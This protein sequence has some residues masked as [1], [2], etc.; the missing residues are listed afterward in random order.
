[1]TYNKELVE[2][3]HTVK[4]TV[5][6]ARLEDI[7]KDIVRVPEEH[8]RDVIGET[9][10]ESTVCKITANH[11]S[12]YAVLRGTRG[13]QAKPEAVA[14]MD[15]KTRNRLGLKKGDEIEFGFKHSRFW[16]QWWW[17]WNASET[18]FRV[19]TRLALVSLALGLLGFVLGVIA[20]I[21]E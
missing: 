21:W 12:T 15:D 11:K 8:R 19:A 17:A 13:V 4:L 6:A 1:M 18:A 10:E 2:S 7:Y 3:G 16:G 9:I 14:M 20:L 5:R